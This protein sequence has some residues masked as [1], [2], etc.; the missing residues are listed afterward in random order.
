[1]CA[2]VQPTA[3]ERSAFSVI[4]VNAMLLRIIYVS[5]AS[6]SLPLE[7]K[8]ILASSRK[9]NRALRVTGA[10]GFLDG[11]YLQY[12]E[13]DAS[14]VTTLY[15]RIEEDPRHSEPKILESKA[16]SERAFPGWSMGLLTWNDET[17]KVFQKFNLSGS[18]DLYD[19]DA[20]TIDS[21]VR[22]LAASAN[23]MALS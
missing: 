15:K 3:Q 12:L 7:L 4:K 19:A 5:R 1:M 8:D 18:L 16:I 20:A 10:M 13:G 9:N 22:S 21:L 14:V 11:L 6:S 2:L 17:K 23:W